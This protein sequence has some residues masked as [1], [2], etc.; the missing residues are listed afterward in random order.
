MSNEPLTAY[1][2]QDNNYVINSIT[3]GDAIITCDKPITITVDDTTAFVVEDSKNVDTLNVDTTTRTVTVN[4]LTATSTIALTTI[5][6]EDPLIRIAND[7]YLLGDTVDFGIYGQY[8]DTPGGTRKYSGLIR[9]AGG[10]GWTFYKDY[11][12]NPDTSPI[13]GYTLDSLTI[14][15]LT[16]T[17]STLTAANNPASVLTVSG[18]TTS[19]DSNLVAAMSLTQTIAPTNP[20]GTMALVTGLN[21]ATPFNPTSS[22]SR[23]I[24]RYATI[25]TAISGTIGSNVTVT[26]LYGLYV[27]S[28]TLTN[29]GTITNAYGLYCEPPTVTNTAVAGVT[30][31]LYSAGLTGLAGNLNMSLNNIYNVGTIGIGTATVPVNGTNRA[32]VSIKGTAN[33][34]SQPGIEFVNSTNPTFTITASSETDQSFLYNCYFDGTNYKYS[35]SSNQASRIRYLNGAL[36]FGTAPTGTAGNNITFNDVFAVTNTYRVGIGSTTS[37]VN[38][39]NRVM[40]TVGGASNS[41]RQPGIE[42]VHDSANGPAMY[43]TSTTAQDQG[44]YF[45]AYLNDATATYRRSN[46]SESPFAIRYLSNTLRLSYAAVGASDSDITFTDGLTLSSSG[47]S[48]SSLLFSG[49][50]QSTLSNYEAGTFSVTF[51]GPFTSTVTALF[52]FIGNMVSITIPDVISTSTSATTMTTSGGPVLSRLRPSIAVN[53][54]IYITVSGVTNIGVVTIGADGNITVATISGGAFGGSG[55]NGFSRFNIAYVI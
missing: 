26:D 37:P 44:I 31:S 18:S 9:K 1:T 35:N 14:A 8:A 27:K 25:N 47:V 15:G 51:N 22:V 10:A 42:F 38:G 28:G 36:L 11:T 39:L 29:N 50:N 54:A 13:T 45:N 43:I 49:S 53:S 3:S 52:H 33:S 20:S 7:N 21:V 40:M 19:T 6:I 34:A 2:E 46:G 24:T 48:V 30:Y 4:N 32:V 12:G 55:S 41:T 17:S 5:S 16:A 23:T